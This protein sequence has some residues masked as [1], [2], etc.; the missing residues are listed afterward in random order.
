[1][2][3]FDQQKTIKRTSDIA[4]SVPLAERIRPKTLD[5]FVGQQHLIGDGKPVRILIEKDELPSMVF[6]GPPG[7]G[8]TTLARI[9]A[10][11]TKADYFQLS[12]VSSGVQEVRK[13]IERAEINRSRLNKKS[14]LFIDEI[15]RFNKAQQD[16]LLH[17]VEDGVIILIGATTENPSFE[18]IS[19]LLSRCFVYVLEPLGAAELNSIIDHA[20]RSDHLL[21][22]QKIQVGKEERELLMLLASGDAR[23]VLNGLE[24]SLRLVKSNKK[25]EHVITLAAIEETFQGRHLKYDKEGEEHYNIISAFIKSM[26]GCDPDGAVYWLARMLEGGE[27]PKFIARRMIILASEDIGNADPFAL[28]LATSCFTAVDYV[29][30]PE[31][32]IILAQTA[33]YLASAPKSNASY[34]A[35]EDALSDVKTLDHYDVPFHIRNA[36]TKLMKDLNYGKDYRYGHSYPEHFIEQQ[37]LPEKLKDKIYYKPSDQGAEQ[38]IHERLNKW[39]RNKKR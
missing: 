32:R 34:M 7:C 12:A 16:A 5:E 38:I 37:Y 9:I 13:I 35:I 28:P 17:S 18:V 23:I 33:T 6:W 22:S 39:W 3:L 30:M 20:L 10:N 15:H 11:Q 8:K 19:P 1:M 26:R 31:A 25:G 24:T 36:P 21:K 2:E 29:G 27:D 4:P 14:I